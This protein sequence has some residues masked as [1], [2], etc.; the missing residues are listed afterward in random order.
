MASP[1]SLGMGWTDWTESSLGDTRGSPWPPTSL[2][3][4]S[5]RGFPWHSLYGQ[6][7]AWG[8]PGDSLGVP[9]RLGWDGQLPGDSPG[10]TCIPW[11]RTGWD[12]QLGQSLAWGTPED[13]LGVPCIP[14][15]T[16][17]WDGQLGHSL[18]L[19]DARGFLWHPLHPD[20]GIHLVSPH[21]TIS[22]W[23]PFGRSKGIQ[24]T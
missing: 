24:W 4:D 20:G 15:G 6:S 19:G 8:M 12:G 17:G 13:S 3:M 5:A 14:W 7:L 1:A 9:H 22:L 11:G 2:G 18:S 16:T 10:V 23:C 21:Y